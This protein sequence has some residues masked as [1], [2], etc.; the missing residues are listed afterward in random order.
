MAK[1]ET[2]EIIPPFKCIQ[3]LELFNERMV[4]YRQAFEFLLKH[5]KENPDKRNDY[6]NH[7]IGV[8]EK[9]Q[10]DIQEFYDY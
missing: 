3:S 6:H 5:A 2:R 9:A 7:V 10:A 8:A 4:A 1:K